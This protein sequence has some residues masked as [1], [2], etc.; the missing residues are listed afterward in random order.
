MNSVKIVFLTITFYF[1]SGL[2]FLS[3]MESE[4]KPAAENVAI[5]HTSNWQQDLVNLLNN[6]NW[7][8]DGYPKQEWIDNAVQDAIELIEDKKKTSDDLLKEL[9]DVSRKYYKDRVIQVKTIQDIK[10]NFLG[11]IK[12]ALQKKSELQRVAEKENKKLQKKQEKHDRKEL[13]LKK[14]E[15]NRQQQQQKLENEALQLLSEQRKNETVWEKYLADLSKEENWHDGAEIEQ[16]WMSRIVKSGGESNV[17]TQ[18]WMEKAA[19]FAAKLIKEDKATTINIVVRALDKALWD[20]YAK[21]PQKVFVE[22]IEFVKDNFYKLLEKKQELERKRQKRQD[23]LAE[24]ERLEQELAEQERLEQEKEERLEQEKEEKLNQEIDKLIRSEE[25][26]QQNEYRLKYQERLEQ[27]KHKLEQEL[28][29]G[30]KPL[31]DTVSEG[32]KKAPSEDWQDNIV[33]VANGLIERNNTPAKRS[34]IYNQINNAINGYSK[35]LWFPNRQA[36]AAAKNNIFKQIY[37]ATVPE[38]KQ[39]AH[40]FKEVAQSLAREDNGIDMHWIYDTKESYYNLNPTTLKKIAD[41]AVVLIKDRM[42]PKSVIENMMSRE[43]VEARRGKHPQLR[44][45]GQ[46]GIMKAISLRE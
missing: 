8:D 5:S 44:S 11:N 45:P 37:S 39:F 41:D 34:E 9:G 36:I 32:W 17:P 14:F 22:T 16:K 6:K 31:L 43:L 30:L 19:E 15:E 42:V 23:R 38:F 4:V 2:N 3:A 10:N 27:K 25:E 35:T 13:F 21:V 33:R 40:Y 46:L 12:V 7:D 20:H 24:Q 1:F 26:K 29:Q 18:A 28:K